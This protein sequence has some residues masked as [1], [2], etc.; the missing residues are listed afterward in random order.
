MRAGAVLEK[1]AGELEGP[2][3]TREP[4][5]SLVRSGSVIWVCLINLDTYIS[6]E[7]FL[8]RVTWSFAEEQPRIHE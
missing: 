4:K 5:G 2:E 3:E 7:N 6:K 8:S 1:G